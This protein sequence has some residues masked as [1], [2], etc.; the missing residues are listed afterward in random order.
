MPSHVFDK[1]KNELQNFMVRF[2]FNFNMKMKFKYLTTIFMFKRV[3]LWIFNT[4]IR[5]SG[6][7]NT[8]RFSF[9][10]FIRELKNKLLEN[11]KINIM[12]IFTSIVCTLFKNKFVSSPRR[13]SAVKGSRGY[14]ESGVQKTADV[15]LMVINPCTQ[16]AISFFW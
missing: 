10:I 5:F 4:L 1:L 8:V 9:F 11:I 16:S 7:R 14:Q 13:F 3:L 6:K 2:C 15:F 12:I